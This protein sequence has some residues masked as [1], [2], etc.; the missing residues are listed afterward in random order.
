MSLAKPGI[1]QSRAGEQPECLAQRS[2]APRGR[3]A[4]CSVR[5]QDDN[6]RPFAVHDDHP[7]VAGVYGQLNWSQNEDYEVN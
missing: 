6:G 7:L 3:R 5:M 1:R 4:G 2:S